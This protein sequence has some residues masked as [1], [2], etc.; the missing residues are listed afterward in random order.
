MYCSE[1]EHTKTSLQ[2][3]E[4]FHR[5]IE[6]CCE[7]EGLPQERELTEEEQ[8]DQEIAAYLL[9]ESRKNKDYYR[10]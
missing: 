4:Q 5:P 8:E 3:R 10:V 2:K 7:R 9:K 6:M 1:C